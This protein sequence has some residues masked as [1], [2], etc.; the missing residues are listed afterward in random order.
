M[1]SS[2]TETNITVTYDDSDNTLDFVPASLEITDSS[3][4]LVGL[5]TNGVQISAGALAI[6]TGVLTADTYVD[7]YCESSNAHYTRLQA[8]AHSAY[9]GNVTATLPVTTGTLAVTSEIPTTE[10]IQDIVGA[11]VSSNTETNITITYQDSDGT[12]DFVV[13]AAQPNVTSLLVL[14]SLTVLIL[15]LLWCTVGHIRR[16]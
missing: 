7:F 9:S 6:K 8:A 11:M 14:L 3:I 5:D 1:V 12:L 13:D 15:C 4:V 10:Q 16:Y 2:N